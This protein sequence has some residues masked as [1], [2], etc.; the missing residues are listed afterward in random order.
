MQFITNLIFRPSKIFDDIFK[1]SDYWRYA[2]ISLILTSIFLGLIIS[3][4]DFAY[5]FDLS[6]FGFLVVCLLSILLFWGLI[7]FL[8]AVVLISAGK[9]MGGKANL[10][11]MITV[12][13]ISTIPNLIV[14]FYELIY[15]LLSKNNTLQFIPP[16]IISF[17]VWIISIRILIVGISKAQKFTYGKA[18]LS[19]F[20]VVIS[21]Q[22]LYLFF[23]G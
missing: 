3:I 21:M 7:K 18:L 17:L 23:K 10:N 9:V 1:Y 2:D 20:V 8:P 13:S 16:F 22:I 11:K 6:M 14:F 4:N 15:L 12:I 19:L 5:Q